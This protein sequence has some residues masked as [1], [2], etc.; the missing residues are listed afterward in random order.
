MSWHEVQALPRAVYDEAVAYLADEADR[1][2]GG[3]G[4]SIDMDAM[5]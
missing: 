2:A 4:I 5:E 1:A 3:D